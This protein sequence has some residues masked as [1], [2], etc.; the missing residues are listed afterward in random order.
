[1]KKLK[2][3]KVKNTGV[4]FE[5][6]TRLLVTETLNQSE[7]KS[8]RLIKRHFGKNS[9][10][11]RELLLYQSL[12]ERAKSPGSATR[13][14]DIVLDSYRTLSRPKLSREKYNLIGDIQ[15]IYDI[16]EFFS[17][18]VSNYKL[19][20][21]IYKMMEYAP[22]DNPSEHIN[23][24]EFIVESLSSTPSEEQE[25]ETEALWKQ[26]P[27]DV[28]KLGFKI[29]VERF[30]RK[31]QGLS[32]RQRGLLSRYINSN[33]TSEEFRNY[34]YTEVTH[35]RSELSKVA[36]QI[37]DDVLTIKVREAVNLTETILASRVVKDEHLSAML[38]YYELIEV[39]N[40]A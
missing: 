1:M 30:D 39:L 37:V 25:N 32:E 21:S 33:T 17:T 6:L 12:Q 10:L 13:M 20:A 26:Q 34:V 8:L 40:H 28:R 22:S 14:V 38:K 9:E 31:Y 5:I 18:R 4:I 15:K 19:L 29:I 27:S 36:D 2:H 35:L 3:S 11:L 24:R 7:Q 16:N 23:C